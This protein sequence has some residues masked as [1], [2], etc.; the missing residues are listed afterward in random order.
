MANPNLVEEVKRR[1]VLTRQP[2][3]PEGTFGKLVVDSG[4]SCVTVEKPWLANARD[5]SC[6]PDGTYLCTWRWSS[7]H[8]CNLYHVENVP[9]R[10]GVEFHSANVHEQLLGCIAPGQDYEDFVAGSL[11]SQLPSV[12]MR[13]VVH[14]RR[15]LAALEAALRDDQGK[16]NSFWLVVQEDSKETS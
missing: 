11:G 10:S 16:Q 8:S 13:G 12:T 5:Q 6:I 4:Y 1:V 15:A 2:S 3:T 14:S 7:K 9:D